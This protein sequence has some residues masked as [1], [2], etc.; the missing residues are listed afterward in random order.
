MEEK[1]TGRGTHRTGL[2]KQGRP[3][4]G[5]L[6]QSATKNFALVLNKIK[7]WKR[8]GL[9]HGCQTR[10]FLLE[11][12]NKKKRTKHS[13]LVVIRKAVQYS[14]DINCGW[15]MAASV[16]GVRSVFQDKQVVKD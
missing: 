7:L 1:K 15:E 16:L 8:G 6:P 3:P 14:L 5:P 12:P 10:I 4:G 11:N 9:H 13:I 2:K